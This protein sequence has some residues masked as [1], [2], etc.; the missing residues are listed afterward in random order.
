MTL[1]RTVGTVR[2]ISR[3]TVVGGACTGLLLVA[4]T[5]GG[6]ACPCAKR[7]LTTVVKQA[8]AIFVGKPL[9]ATTDSA[10]MGSQPNLEYQA[11]FAFD[12]E[13]VLKGSTPRATTVVTP[14]G[15]C[16]A[17]FAV[18]TDYLVIGRR[19]GGGLF[20]DACQGNVA[21]V[22][23]IRARAAAIR[24]ELAPKDSR[25]APTTAP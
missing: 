10:T 5:A 22:E 3:S 17:G 1:Q 7:D 13:V 19:Q 23:A 12:V 2:R 25:P 4:S 24:A 8:D 21:G 6:Q 9:A 11:R 15:P 16:G 18:G 20:T 14:S